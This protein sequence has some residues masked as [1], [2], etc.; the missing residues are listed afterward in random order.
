MDVTR[1][2]EVTVFE[3]HTMV[4]GALAAPWQC[5]D[6]TVELVPAPLT[7]FVTTYEHS[8]AWPAT[9]CSLLHWLTEVAAAACG[10]ATKNATE[11]SETTTMSAS[12]M[13]GL[14][15]AMR[16]VIFSCRFYECSRCGGDELSRKREGALREPP[17]LIASAAWGEN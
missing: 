14:G 5:V 17:F 9:L 7:V 4:G 10:A 12:N 3:L 6:S 2:V 11:T 15:R 8:T 1:S 13:P 16:C